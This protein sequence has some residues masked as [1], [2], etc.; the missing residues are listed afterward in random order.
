MTQSLD[1]PTEREA[2]EAQ[3]TDIEIAVAA[4]GAMP[5]TDERPTTEQMAHTWDV[6][7]RTIQRTAKRDTVMMLRRLIMAE[8]IDERVIPKLWLSALDEA[9]KDGKFAFKMLTYL[10]EHGFDIGI[11]QRTA[12]PE[13]LGGGATIKLP[14]TGSFDAAIRVVRTDSGASSSG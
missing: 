13:P 10:E 11:G 2:L 14:V 12:K 7:V 3:M 8:F 5:E 1:I 6:T 4:W 9:A